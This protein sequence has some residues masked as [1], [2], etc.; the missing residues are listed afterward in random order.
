M[1]LKF[2][3]KFKIASVAIYVWGLGREDYWEYWKRL[4]VFTRIWIRIIIL[5][6]TMPNRKL[7]K[8]IF[9]RNWI[10]D[11]YFQ[12]E[13]YKFISNKKSKTRNVLF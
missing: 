3:T 6:R 1:P 2:P 7:V 4:S 13:S 8:V 5:Q 12:N 10:T 11:N 9:N